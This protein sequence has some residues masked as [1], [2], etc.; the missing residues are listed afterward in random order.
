MNE[1]VDRK[2]KAAGLSPG[3]IEAWSKK[4]GLREGSE[5]PIQFEGIQ[6]VQ[7]LS[8]KRQGLVR[9]ATSHFVGKSANAMR[10]FPAAVNDQGHRIIPKPKAS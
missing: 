6:R 3:G 7:R 4:R 10:A 9:N 8:V 2:V 5:C 1:I